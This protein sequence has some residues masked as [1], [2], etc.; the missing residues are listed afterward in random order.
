MRQYMALPP[1]ARRAAEVA[2]VC[3]E[4]H[5]PKRYVEPLILRLSDMWRANDEEAKARVLQAKRKA[6]TLA[7]KGA[8]R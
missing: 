6:N 7:R 2:L 4:Q 1:H 8:P 3:V 5:V